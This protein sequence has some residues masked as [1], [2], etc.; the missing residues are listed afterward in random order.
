MNSR[1]ILI[2]ACGAVRGKWRTRG[3]PCGGRGRALTMRPSIR[4]FF[5]RNTARAAL[6]LLYYINRRENM[7]GK[8]E[9]LRRRKLRGGVVRREKTVQRRQQVM[10][11]ERTWE[12]TPE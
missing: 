12:S 2:F 11:S 3:E 9:K 6:Y 7:R 8:Q 4:F 5:S 10:E 1:K